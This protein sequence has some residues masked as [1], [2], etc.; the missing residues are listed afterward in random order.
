MSRVLIA[1]ADPAL[2]TAFGLILQKK[3]G[4]SEM[5]EVTNLAQLQSCLQTWQPDIMLLDYNLPG[6]SEAGGLA[7]HC[8]ALPRPVIVLSIR[9]EDGSLALADGADDFIYKSFAPE[10]VLAIIKKYM[11]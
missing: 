1:D 5:K 11:P 7:A 8:S 9:A 10:Q 4:V 6:L 3:L 2:R